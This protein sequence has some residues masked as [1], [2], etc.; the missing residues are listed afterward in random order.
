MGFGH[1]KFMKRLLL[2]E[3][4]FC[5]SMLLCGCHINALDDLGKTPSFDGHLELT[6]SVANGLDSS[7][8]KAGLFTGKTTEV[9]RKDG[10]SAVTTGAL[11]V[12]VSVGGKTI[13]DDVEGEPIDD[14]DYALLTPDVEYQVAVEPFQVNL[15]A[16]PLSGTIYYVVVW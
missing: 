14:V 10:T 11:D 13:L 2:P 16:R 3:S 5:L 1:F 4:I 7:L 8:V 12:L 6:V 15:P 9:F